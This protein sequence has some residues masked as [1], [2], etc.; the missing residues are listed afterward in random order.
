MILYHH[1]S[2]IKTQKIVS[3]RF[4]PD[5]IELAPFVLSECDDRLLKLDFVV[6][7]L[8]RVREQ[9]AEW[10]STEKKSKV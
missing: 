4:C 1:V 7:G 5:E 10:R 8:V 9:V 6:A 2:R 3:Q